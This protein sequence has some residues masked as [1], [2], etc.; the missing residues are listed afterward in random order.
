MLVV[1]LAVNCAVFSVVGLCCAVYIFVFRRYERPNYALFP[2]EYCYERV[3]NVLAR[4][5]FYFSAGES[6]LK[7]YYYTANDSKKLIVLVHGFHSGADD[8]LPM[9]KFY[10]ENGFN[11]FSYDATGV[12]DSK[13]YSYVGMCQPLVDLDNVLSY[14]NSNSLYNEQKLFLVGHSL[15]GYGVCSALAFHKNVKGC[16]AF[17][18][19]TYATTVMAD[20]AKAK[21]GKLALL[22]KPVFSLLQKITFGKYTCFNSLNGIN[23]TDI[24]VLIVQGVNDSVI[25]YSSLSLV[26]HK[27]EITNPNALF[28]TVNGISGTHNDLWCSET[29]VLYR[30]K[31]ENELKKACK[32]KGA[33]LSYKEKSEYYKKVDNEKYSRI[34]TDIL[35]K[36]LCVFKE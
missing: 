9:I 23:S 32:K 31:V 1:F 5:E 28:I 14:I 35:R 29:S 15:G 25:T 11:V 30:E 21:A 18:P 20:M 27:N 16:V 7:G 26:A 12:Y 8:F 13:G 10:V 24:P 36:T 19:V 34:N 6:V 17:A 2:G 4:N 22:C 3:K 33:K